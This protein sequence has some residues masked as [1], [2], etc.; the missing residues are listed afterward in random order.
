MKAVL[1]LTAAFG[2]ALCAAAPVSAQGTS[3]PIVSDATASSALQT[4]VHGQATPTNV[5]GLDACNLEDS[6][7]NVYSISHQAGALTPTSSGP[8]GLALLFIP[9]LP[10][11]ARGQLAALTQLGLKV[12]IGTDELSSVGGLGDAALWVRSTTAGDGLYVQRGPDAFAF[13]SDDAPG[14][15]SALTALAQAVVTSP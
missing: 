10:D 7:G 4:D 3:C 11:S 5:A 1:S 12:T 8:V 15:Q 6:D 13:E 14:T 9:D 2:L